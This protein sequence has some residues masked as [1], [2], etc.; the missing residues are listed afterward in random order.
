MKQ[1]TEAEVEAPEEEAEAISEPPAADLLPVQRSSLAIEPAAE[2]THP[3]V[4]MAME[5]GS[6]DPASIRELMTLQREWEAGEAKKSFT[7]AM[8]AMKRQIPNV[9]KR[10]KLVDYATKT[11]GRTTYTHVSL[12]AAVEAVTPHV[13]NHGFSAAFTTQTLERNYVEVT[14]TLTHQDGHAESCVLSAPP[15]KSGQKSDAQA[16]ASTVTLLQRYTLLSLL[17]IAT[18]DHEDPQPANVQAT[19]TVDEIITMFREAKAPSHIRDARKAWSDIKSSIT[20]EDRDELTLEQ[21]EAVKRIQEAQ[22]S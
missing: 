13:C 6:L 9:L 11:G 8:V 20:A 22:K 12:A 10:D 17:G 18:K 16:V 1:V 7:R 5:A 4:R 3:L 14:C 21:E 19:K 2:G 15:D